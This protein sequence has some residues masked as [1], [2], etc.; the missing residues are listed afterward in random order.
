MDGNPTLVPERIMALDWSYHGNKGGKEGLASESQS[1]VTERSLR[2][3]R[4]R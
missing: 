3:L 1:P 4:T 2:L